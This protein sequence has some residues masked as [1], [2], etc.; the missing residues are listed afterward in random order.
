MFLVCVNVCVKACNGLI[1]VSG[2][3]EYVCVCERL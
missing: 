1:Y 3:C 2:V